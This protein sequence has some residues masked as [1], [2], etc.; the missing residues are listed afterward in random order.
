MKT[1]KYKIRTLYSLITNCKTKWYIVYNIYFI[2][3]FIVLE[4][5]S[6]GKETRYN[7]FIVYLNWWSLPVTLMQTE[8]QISLGEKYWND[9]NINF[10][11]LVVDRKFIENTAMPLRI[12]WWSPKLFYSKFVELCPEITASA[13]LTNRFFVISYGDVANVGLSSYS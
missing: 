2:Y 1:N 9:L 7:V 8:L 11:L 13:H 3:L 6:Q 4:K 5:T 12:R 10:S